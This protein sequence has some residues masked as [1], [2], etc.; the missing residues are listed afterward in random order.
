LIYAFF[1]IQF[2]MLDIS[3]DQLVNWK[4]G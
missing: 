3:R 2:L 1:N 4:N